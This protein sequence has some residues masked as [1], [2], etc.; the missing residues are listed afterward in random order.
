MKTQEEYKELVLN[1]FP[2]KQRTLEFIRKF[3]GKQ[4]DRAKQ[5]YWQHPY[6]VAMRSLIEIDKFFKV[7]ERNGYKFVPWEKAY[8]E[9]I[10]YMLCLCHDLYEDTNVKDEDLKELGFNDEFIFILKEYLTHPSNIPY[11]QYIN[12]ISQNVYATLTKMSDLVDNLDL[13]RLEGKQLKETDFERI[14]KYLDSY[15][16]LFK[17]LDTQIID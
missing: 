12:H 9:L 11:N 1:G 6:R 7:I 3:H 17:S 2:G 13:S 14:Q 4:K 10:V 5:P 16:F 8:I 15:H